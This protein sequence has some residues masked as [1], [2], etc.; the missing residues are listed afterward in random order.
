MCIVIISVPDNQKIADM[1]TWLGSKSIKLQQPFHKSWDE[2]RREYVIAFD[3]KD[4][5]EAKDF[6]SEWVGK[7]SDKEHRF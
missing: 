3:F 2:A 1:W 5:K 6:Q 4:A 7:Q